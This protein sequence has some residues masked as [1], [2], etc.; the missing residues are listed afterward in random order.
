MFQIAAHK[1]FWCANFVRGI[2]YPI[3]V[4]YNFK[5]LKF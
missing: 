2:L 1:Y 3:C 4:K 5:L